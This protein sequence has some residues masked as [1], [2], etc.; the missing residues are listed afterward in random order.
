MKNLIVPA[1]FVLLLFANCHEEV[2][3]PTNNMVPGT[4]TGPNPMACPTICCSGWFIDIEGVSYH[5]LD[6]PADSE[7]TAADIESYPVD[8]QLLYEDS[9]ECWDNSIV[10]LEIEA[11]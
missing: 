10:V 6:F 5:F 4:I 9:D 3:P 8:V 11:L 1:I 2:T 7:F